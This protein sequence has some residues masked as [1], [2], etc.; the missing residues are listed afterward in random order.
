MNCRH[1]GLLAGLLSA[2]L[3]AGC[4][5]DRPPE[6][7]PGGR[8]AE[9]GRFDPLPVNEQWKV[10]LLDTTMAMV[11]SELAYPATARFDEASHFDADY[12]KTR[13]VTEFKVFGNAESESSYG[14]TSKQ[15][16]YVVW[17]RLGDV[18]HPKTGP[19]LDW[20][21]GGFKILDSQFEW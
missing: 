10:D 20:K 3:A 6:M 11:K 21:L 18:R 5:S 12:D 16:Y 4:G 13:R 8:V 15:S 19:P 2:L 17:E 7:G 1:V 14:Q 9:V